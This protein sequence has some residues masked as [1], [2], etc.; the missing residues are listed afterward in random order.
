MTR[1][2]KRALHQPDHRQ[3]TTKKRHASPA[4]DTVERIGHITTT[5]LAEGYDRAGPNPH[6][7]HTG[8]LIP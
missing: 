6:P 7:H 1:E 8:R 2:A 3:A 5:R 4:A